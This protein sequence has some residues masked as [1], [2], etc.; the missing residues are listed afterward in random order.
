MIARREFVPALAKAR[1]AKNRKIEAESLEWIGAIGMYTGVPISEILDYFKQAMSIN[2]EINDLV[3]QRDIHNKIGY[4]LVAQGEGD[5][6]R[7]KFHYTAGL[8]LSHQMGFPLFGENC[9]RNLGVLHTYTG[10]YHQAEQA[11]LR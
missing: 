11:V 2:Q 3:G 6:E 1:T 10:D 7:A 4:A 8:E 5:Y 9:W